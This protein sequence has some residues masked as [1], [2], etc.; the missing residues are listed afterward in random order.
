MKIV[1]VVN[2]GTR[3]SGHQEPVCAAGSQFSWTMFTKTKNFFHAAASAMCR[4]LPR[5]PC[6]QPL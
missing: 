1:S 5:R 6:H 2:R 3:P 4:D